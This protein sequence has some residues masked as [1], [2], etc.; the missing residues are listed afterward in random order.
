MAKSRIVK[1]SRPVYPPDGPWR[2]TDEQGEHDELLY[3]DQWLR[4]SMGGRMWSYYYAI[5]SLDEGW[6]FV[7]RIKQQLYFW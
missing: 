7:R 3:P 1:V 4:E 6:Q 5:W 2:A